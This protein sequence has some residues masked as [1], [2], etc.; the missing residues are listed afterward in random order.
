MLDEISLPHLPLR[1]AVTGKFPAQGVH[2]LCDARLPQ[3]HRMVQPRGELPRR[4]AVI[5]GRTEDDERV[6]GGGQAAPPA[7]VEENTDHST[8]GSLGGMKRMLPRPKTLAA[9]AMIG[10]AALI[11]GAPLAMA[12]T[13]DQVLAQAPATAVAPEHLSPTTPESSTPARAPT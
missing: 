1:E 8:N 6:G 2:M 10:A 3:P 12:V 13:G 9:S 5:L 4:R 7:G 11:G